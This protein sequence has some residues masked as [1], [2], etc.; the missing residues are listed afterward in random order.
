MIREHSTCNNRAGR[1]IRERIEHSL[2]AQTIIQS[3]D[4]TSCKGYDVVE[5]NV[6][7]VIECYQRTSS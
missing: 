2:K 3:S 7:R 1:T 4:V 6:T 5:G